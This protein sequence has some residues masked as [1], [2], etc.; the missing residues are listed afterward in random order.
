ML[1]VSSNEHQ[2]PHWSRSDH[3]HVIFCSQLYLSAS[4]SEDGMV[5]VD[6]NASVA[7]ADGEA[8]AHLHASDVI[9]TEH[10]GKLLKYDL[11]MDEMEELALTTREP[12]PLA[13]DGDSK[14]ISLLA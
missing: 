9:I 2:A 1:V 14:F 13:V 11:R 7:T 6:G 3:L 4:V 5:H 8:R 10:L 12:G